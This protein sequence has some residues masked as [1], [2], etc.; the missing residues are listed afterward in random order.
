MGVFNF[1]KSKIII[2]S[3]IILI[4]III[5]GHQLTQNKIT[6]MENTQNLTINQKNID[7]AIL[8]GGCFW[9]I[10]ASLEQ[11]EGIISVESGYT[12]GHT[13]NPTYSEVTSGKTGHYEAVQVKFDKTKITYK[14]VLEEFFKLFDPTDDTGSFA[15]KGSQYK[16]AIF[17]KNENE[18][19]TAENLIQNYTNSKIYDKSIVTKIIENQTFYIAEEYHQDYYKKAPLRYNTYKKYSGR[20][21]YFEKMND[22]KTNN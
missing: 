11:I 21:E 6:K 17:Y 2:I 18:K 1:K 7:T 3:I 9:C 16:S 8:A 4:L 13:N 14:K 12:G 15:D 20:P 19:Q 22:S 10:E 5:T